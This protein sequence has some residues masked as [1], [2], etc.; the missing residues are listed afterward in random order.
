MNYKQL[1]EKLNRIDDTLRVSRHGKQY[2]IFDSFYNCEVAY[3]LIADNVED[4]QLILRNLKFEIGYDAVAVLLEFAKQTKDEI[5]VKHY[6]VFDKSR[7]DG[8]QAICLQS[9]TYTFGSRYRTDEKGNSVSEL[10]RD[11]VLNGLQALNCNLENLEIV[12]V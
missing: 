8:Y 6:A 9:E 10:T 11:Q 7:K 3:I 2:S 1:K 12:E 5:N 4:N